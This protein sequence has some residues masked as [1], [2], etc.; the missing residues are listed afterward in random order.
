LHVDPPDRALVLRCDGKSQCQALE[1]TQPGLPLGVGHIRTHT[2][3]CIRHGTITLFAAL[4]HLEGKIISRTESRHA[5]V[6]W[7]RFLKQIDRETPKDLDI[8]LIADNCCT[9]KHAKAK[10]WLDR[11]RRFHM[12]FTP[13][14]AFWMNL[15]ERFFADPARDVV[16]EGSFCSVRQ[17]VKEI[18]IHLAERN[19]HP[20]PCQWKAKG[21]DILAKIHR[22][23][24]AMEQ[25]SRP[26]Q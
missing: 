14:S 12:H 17:L 15:V 25:S 5:H 2:H 21:K 11:H 26:L 10:A 23:R 3:D 22:A 24:I 4:N 8:H 19:E 7:L 13:T 6:E 20:K 18:E 16:R 1:R 9:R